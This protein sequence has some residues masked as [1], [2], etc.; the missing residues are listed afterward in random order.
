MTRFN[1]AARA[2]TGALLALAI[3]SAVHSEPPGQPPANPPPNAQL[4]SNA[5]RD[6]CAPA[7]TQWPAYVERAWAIKGVGP[8]RNKASAE[9]DNCRPAAD[10]QNTPG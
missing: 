4:P 10:R 1:L 9:P 6:H 3:A 8:R 5:S 2:A 7:A